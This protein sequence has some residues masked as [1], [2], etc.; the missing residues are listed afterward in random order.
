MTGAASPHL[1]ASPSLGVAKEAEPGK[2]EVAQAEVAEIMVNMTKELAAELAV[3]RGG[4]LRLRAVTIPLVGKLL[5][6]EKELSFSPAPLK[7]FLNSSPI[8]T[9]LQSSL[10]QL[11]TFKSTLIQY[12]RVC[13]ELKTLSVTVPSQGR[14]SRAEVD[15]RRTDPVIDKTITVVSTQD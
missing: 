2:V 15:E 4:G 13:P 9:S 3:I 6:G 1:R 7:T 8:P 5:Q 14:P 10:S 12:L 11:T